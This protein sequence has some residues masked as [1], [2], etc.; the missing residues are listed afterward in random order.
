MRLRDKELSQRW[1][2]LVTPLRLETGGGIQRA[3][4]VNTEGIFRI[5]HS[6]PSPKAEPFKRWLAQVG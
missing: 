5:I 2:Q 1:G 4:C 6:I 3:N